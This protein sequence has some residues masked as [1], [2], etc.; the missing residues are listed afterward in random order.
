MRCS[1]GW[2]GQLV[3]LCGGRLVLG[4]TFFP[5][6]T[7]MCR[8]DQAVARSSMTA[9]CNRNRSS[10]CVVNTFHISMW[11]PSL[12]LVVSITTLWGALPTRHFRCWILTV[13]SLSNAFA[14]KT[15]YAGLFANYPMKW[16]NKHRGPWQG[17][18][19]PHARRVGVF[20]RFMG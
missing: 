9:T 18:R 14:F 6:F 1:N 4:W 3:A 5:L 17:V 16:T 7:Q 8:H 15:V 11:P 12:S 10:L 19:S 13:E 20:A 2:K